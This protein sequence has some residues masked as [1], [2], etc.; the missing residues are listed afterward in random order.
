MVGA[1]SS[2]TSTAISLTSS[3]GGNS[4]AALEAQ[5]SAKE[6]ELAEAQDEEIKAETEPAAKQA[7]QTSESESISQIGTS[8][9]EDGDPFG[10]REIY[11]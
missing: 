2:T 5:L 9:I 3:S 4:Q 7:A 8:N 11:V 10:E 1:I 6:N